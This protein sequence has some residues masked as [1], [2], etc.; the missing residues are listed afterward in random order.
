MTA[1]VSPISSAARFGDEATLLR[2]GAQ[3]AQQRRWSDNLPPICARGRQ[4]S[5]AFENRVLDI[6]PAVELAP[7]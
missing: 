2:P 6:A 4:N 5:A 1:S 3:L 7:C